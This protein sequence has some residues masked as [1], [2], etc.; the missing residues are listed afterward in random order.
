MGTIER[1]RSASP[2]VLGVIAV[3]F[4][5]FMVMSDMNIQTSFRQGMGDNNKNVGKVNGENIEYAKFEEAVKAQIDQMRAQANNPDQEIDETAIRQQVWDQMVEEILVRQEAKKAGII[6]T[7]E[8]IADVMLENP[9]DFLKKN[10]IDSNGVFHKDMYQKLLTDPENFIKDNSPKEMTD[11]EKQIQIDKFRKQLLEIEDFLLKQKVSEGMKSVVS[12]ASAQYSPNF[13]SKQFNIENS[14]LDA[15]T[16]Y[17]P[18]SS[19]PDNQVNVG[20]QEIEKYFNDHK[21]FYKQKPARKLKFVLIPI[22]P[23]AQDTQKIQK[24]IQQLQEGIAQAQT[25]ALKDSI[26]N[27]KLAEYNGKANNYT[28]SKDIDPTKL[29]ILLGM[30]DKTFAGP[31][32]TPEGTSFFKLDGKRKGENEVV[33]ASHILIKFGA[34]KDS[35][36]AKAEDLYKKAKGGEDFADLARKNSA[37]GSAQQGGDLGYFGKGKM[38]KEF[39]NAAFGASVGSIVGPI[40]T[41]FGYHIIKV[42]DKTSE[43]IKYSE[44]NFTISVSSQTRKQIKLDAMGIKQAVEAGQ[45]FDDAAKAKNLQATESNLFE[46]QMPMLNSQY[47]TAFAFD[48]KIN[49]VCD[50]LEIKHYGYVIAQVSDVREAGTKLLQDVKEQIKAK[51]AKLKKLDMVKSKAEALFAKVSG[52]D[53]LNKATDLEGFEV[54]L[55]AGV[56]ENG[57][58]VIYGQD[59]VFTT[60]AYASQIGKIEGPVRGETGYYIY[61]VINRSNPDENKIKNDMPAFS[62]QFGK[63]FA[64]SGYFKWFNLIKEK[65][66]IE[67]NRT[68]IYGNKF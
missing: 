46:R 58:T 38:I 63:R 8:E 5:V 6:V 64:N 48:N 52:L 35:A 4:I 28:L 41:Q 9:P 37:D 32:Q 17:V 56:K 66:K 61:Q 18:A 55:A 45:T 44:I 43:E 51:L 42:T 23:S 60:K 68:K 15:Y 3:V 40:E 24:R 62:Q 31:I 20:D 12:V 29:A 19:I 39:E 65:A 54:K 49:T 2:W 30:A 59:N 34:N 50:P 13:A 25:E 22:V 7:K 21:A 14:N 67:D 16:L 36:K 33:K 1:M 57:Q 10:W 26:F 47:L 27:Q 11:E 53:S